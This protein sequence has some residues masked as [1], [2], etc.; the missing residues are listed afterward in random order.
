MNPQIDPDN[1]GACGSVCGSSGTTR[2]CAAGLCQCRSG[3]SRCPGDTSPS[4]CVTDL[5]S[6]PNNCGACGARCG[7]NG[8]S[9]TCSNGRCG[10]DSTHERCGGDGS[11]VLSCE[12]STVTTSDCGACGNV[13]SFPNAI[14]VC[15]SEKCEVGSCVVG[16]GDCGAGA[17]CEQPLNVDAHCGAC[18]RACPPGQECEDP[19]N[20][21]GSCESICNANEVYCNGSCAMETATQCGC[22]RVNCN[23][24]LATNEIGRCVDSQCSSMCP[25]NWPKC[26]GGACPSPNDDR[27]CG[28]GCVDCDALD[29]IS[30]ASCN[31]GVCQFGCS[32]SFENCDGN[33]L[34]GCETDTDESEAHCGGC[35]RPCDGGETCDNGV[36]R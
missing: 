12:T 30:N 35:N 2:T 28:A 14:P 33:L 36:C 18:N 32:G 11:G 29:N 20:G 24:G 25:N 13:C 3:F 27:R 21:V 19:G 10:C 22:P 8:T 16:F 5:N 34:T 17:G 9:R 26:G 23:Q 7:S 4:S 15:R 31:S 1:C 6:D